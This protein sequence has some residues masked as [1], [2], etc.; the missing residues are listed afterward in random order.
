MLELASSIRLSASNKAKIQPGYQLWITE[1]AD[2]TTEKFH[3]AAE[4]NV[5][6]SQLWN[7]VEALCEWLPKNNNYALLNLVEYPALHSK[8]TARSDIWQLLAGFSDALIHDTFL[9]WGIAYS[10]E[11]SFTEVYV[12]GGK[13]IKF[14]GMDQAAFES[15]MRK[16]NLHCHDRIYAVTDFNHTRLLA[17][18]LD[19]NIPPALVTYRQLGEILFPQLA[20]VSELQENS[21]A[22]AGGSA[23]NLPKEIVYLG[24]HKLLSRMGNYS[25]VNYKSTSSD[26]AQS[27]LNTQSVS[28]Y[29]Q[30]ISVDTPE[31]RWTLDCDEIDFEEESDTDD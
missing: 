23:N 26:V 6:I 28:E 11:K 29:G 21:F 31:G 16:F 4:I 22:L 8:E 24:T 15:V 17:N 1:K 19:A 30:Y 18:D 12:T 3:F 2:L 10:D 25:Y 13:S 7:I 9:E 14:W 20:T 27:F 5:D